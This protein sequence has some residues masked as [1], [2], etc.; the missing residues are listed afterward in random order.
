VRI[1][2][3][4]VVR[5]RVEVTLLTLIK[6]SVTTMLHLLRLFAAPS[7]GVEREDAEENE[8]EGFEI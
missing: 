3:I 2:G 5:D 1:N 4:T 8:P 6:N 7:K